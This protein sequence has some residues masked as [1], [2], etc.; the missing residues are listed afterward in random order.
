VHFFASLC[1]AIGLDPERIVYVGDDP[2]NDYAGARAA[3]L[4][5]VLFDPKGIE[6]SAGITRITRLAE[7]L[8]WVGEHP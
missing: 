7:V 4:R 6:P 1:R 5:P 2:A 8:R 3:G